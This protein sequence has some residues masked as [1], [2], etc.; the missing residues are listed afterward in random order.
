MHEGRSYSLDHLSEFEWIY[1]QPAKDSK[2]EKSYKFIVEFSLHCFTYGPNK[3]KGET[4]NSLPLELHYSDSRET[5]AFC[6]KRWELSF[7]LPDI[8]KEISQRN[9]FNTGKGNF[10]TIELVNEETGNTED[11]EIYF[12]VSRVK[13]GWL[14]LYI[15]S[16]YV[17]DR[18]HGTDQPEKKK[19]NFF[20]IANNVQNNKPIK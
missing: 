1:T 10:F 6:F 18:E 2:P 17:R 19:I 5:R 7:K 15:E 4:V 14:R 9:C 8:A 16:A 12:K 20:V 11:Y 3:N 13:K